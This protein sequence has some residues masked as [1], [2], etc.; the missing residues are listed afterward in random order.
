[1]RRLPLDLPA[2]SPAKPLDPTLVW[3]EETPGDVSEPLPPNAESTSRSGG[4]SAGRVAALRG[5]REPATSG[6]PTTLEPAEPGE[7]SD[8]G[9]TGTSLPEA[10]A[11]LTSS[12]GCTVTGP[13]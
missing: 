6:A 10:S 9:E 1:M 4:V 3:L 5:P 7:P 11:S 12:A 8:P 2:P 13:C